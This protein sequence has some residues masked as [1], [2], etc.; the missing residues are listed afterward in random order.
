M[1]SGRSCVCATVEII[2]FCFLC[3]VSIADVEMWSQPPL[4]IPPMGAEPNFF[5]LGLRAIRDVNYPAGWF[6]G[7]DR[8]RQCH[9]DVDGKTSGPPNYYRVYVN[10]LSLLVAAWDTIYDPFIPGNLYEPNADC[11]RDGR[12]DYLDVVE[13]AR[14][15]RW[16]DAY[17]PANCVAAH[18][19]AIMV[20]DDFRWQSSRPVTSVEWWGSY[21]NWRAPNVN[22]PSTQPDSW[23]IGLWD[24]IPDPNPSDS[25]T[26]WTFGR[27]DKLLRKISI[28]SSRVNV[29]LSGHS[30]PWW[31]TYE[32]P[33]EVVFNYTVDLSSEEYLWPGDFN[34]QGN[35]YWLSILPVYPSGPN[36]ANPWGWHIRPWH[37]QESAVMTRLYTEPQ[38]GDSMDANWTLPVYDYSAAFV[39]GDITPYQGWDMTFALHTDANLFKWQQPYTGIRDWPGYE[40]ISSR[41]NSSGAGIVAADDWRCEERTPV[42]G[43]IWWGSYIGARYNFREEMQPPINKPDYFLL[44]IWTNQ[45]AN[46]PGN[47]YLF[48]HPQQLIW[49]FKANS[50]DEVMAGYDRFPDSNLD[51]C[52]PVFR[53]SVEIPEPNWF[54]QHEVNGIY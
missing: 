9:G 18:P 29:Q 4:E 11:T 51:P 37:C 45:D 52:E 1:C 20:A 42:V 33:L 31:F 22:I 53:Y 48:N 24:N 44:S 47:P 16:T 39:G 26:R 25:Y 14:W 13:L 21:R 23:Q 32:S 12:V 2:I 7:W 27:P 17:M 54:Y 5:G 50:Y 36:H 8:S 10:D 35:C 19:W 41:V 6:N 3:S 30:K 46:E 38:P 49:Q 40:D 34:S 28:P 43:I 15:W